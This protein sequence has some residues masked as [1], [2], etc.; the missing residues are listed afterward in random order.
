MRG[1]DDKCWSCDF[2]E[3]SGNDGD[4]IGTCQRFPPSIRDTEL[5]DDRGTVFWWPTTY[6]EMWCGEYVETTEAILDK[7]DKWWEHEEKRPIRQYSWFKRL[8]KRG[9]KRVAE[10]WRRR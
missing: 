6:S 8:C 5:S 7:R 9:L 4:P 3:P 2:W 1:N 10:Y